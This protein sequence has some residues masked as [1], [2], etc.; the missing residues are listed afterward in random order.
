M[1]VQSPNNG[2][3]DWCVETIT[4]V[5]F[6]CAVDAV[7][8]HVVKLLVELQ[9]SRINNRLLPLI[10]RQQSEVGNVPSNLYC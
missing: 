3:T 8:H 10:A 4:F 9:A 2:I 7:L 5:D 6:S 1:L